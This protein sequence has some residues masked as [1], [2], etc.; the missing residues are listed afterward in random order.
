M[1]DEV[2]EALGKH[3]PNAASTIFHQAEK[4]EY[5]IPA[6][7]VIKWRAQPDDIVRMIILISTA[8]YLLRAGTPR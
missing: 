1:P 3:K 6:D 4:C 2:K 5:E 7:A 8:H